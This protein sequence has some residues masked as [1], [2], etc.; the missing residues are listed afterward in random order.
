MTFQ[1]SK[2]SNQDQSVPF[3]GNYPSR[4]QES[5]L[6]LRTVNLLPSGHQSFKKWTI[7]WLYQQKLNDYPHES[8]KITSV[9]FQAISQLSNFDRGCGCRHAAET[10]GEVEVY[11]NAT[12][13]FQNVHG[14]LKRMWTFLL[15]DG[16]SRSRAVN[17]FGVPIARFCVAE[18]RYLARKLGRRNGRDCSSCK[19]EYATSNRS[20]AS[21][22]S[23]TGALK[24]G[25]LVCLA[26]RASTQSMI[27]SWT[28][29]F[30]TSF[31]SSQ[32]VEL[33]QVSVVDSW[34]LSL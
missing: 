24:Q 26:F 27:D 9:S 1:T 8:L 5:I 21:D 32:S 10:A 11:G 28:K 31:H 33:L 25:T 34:F 15:K 12:P 4:K 17:L 19:A 14:C 7:E 20:K 13:Q 30:L 23:Q 29:L 22:K 18:I 3:T 2:L 16:K 6:K